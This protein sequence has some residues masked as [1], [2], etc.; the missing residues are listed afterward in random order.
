MRSGS[1]TVPKAAWAP[2]LSVTVASG[3]RVPWDGAG[4]GILTAGSRSRSVPRLI[5]GLR[6]SSLSFGFLDVECKGWT[7]ESW[8]STTLGHS[9]LPQANLTPVLHGFQ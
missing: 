4:L 6:Q 8:S 1:Q 5:R 3:R 7:G 2:Q 9:G